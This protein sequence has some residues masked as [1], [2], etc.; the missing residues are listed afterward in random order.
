MAK[1]KRGGKREGAGRKVAN[2]E[3]KTVPI[4]ASVPETLVAS[5]DALAAEKQ[6]N[7]SAAVTEAIRRLVKAK[8]K[9]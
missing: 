6:W 2:P 7:R 3:G 1:A 9:A 4:V 5:L 8:R